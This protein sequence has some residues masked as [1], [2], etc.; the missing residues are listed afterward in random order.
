MGGAGS[1]EAAGVGISLITGA[2]VEAAA[3][4]AGSTGV[5]V[6]GTAGAAAG[7][8]V[9]EAAAAAAGLE[10]EDA[11][12]VLAWIEKQKVTKDKKSRV[13]RPSEA[14]MWQG[15]FSPVPMPLSRISST[16]SVPL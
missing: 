12:E 10:E 1:V 9:D 15:Y 8:G 2:A 6:T 3:T 16:V 5:W 4:G 7:A 13:E 14:E 11:G